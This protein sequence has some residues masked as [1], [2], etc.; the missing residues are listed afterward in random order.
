MEE[1]NNTHV[2]SDIE[3]KKVSGAAYSIATQIGLS[4]AFVAVGSYVGYYAAGTVN[5]WGMPK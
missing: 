1:I 4:V 5:N 3:I 2:L